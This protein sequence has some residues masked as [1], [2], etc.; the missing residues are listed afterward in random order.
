MVLESEA[1]F[2]EQNR[3]HVNYP[4]FKMRH[5]KVMKN[6]TNS[7]P[8]LYQ[9]RDTVLQRLHG[10]L[11][12]APDHVP[13]EVRVQAQVQVF[14]EAPGERREGAGVRHDEGPVSAERLTHTGSGDP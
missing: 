13:V 8:S 12:L 11:H 9:N 2:T 7:E 6:F 3:L 14:G 5:I 1:N 4:V 10:E